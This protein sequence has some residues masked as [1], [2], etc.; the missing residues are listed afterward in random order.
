MPGYAVYAAFSLSHWQRMN[1][2]L[3]MLRHQKCLREGPNHR[4]FTVLELR[5]PQKTLVFLRVPKLK[6]RKYHMIRTLPE[7]F[8]L[9]KY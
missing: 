9:L 8:L 1:V 2:C 5:D 7:A 6:Y 4:V 3:L